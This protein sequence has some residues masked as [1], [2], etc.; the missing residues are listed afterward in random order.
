VLDLAGSFDRTRG[1]SA[2]VDLAALREYRVRVRD[3]DDDTA[4]ATGHHDLARLSTLAADR[5]ALLDEL[6]RVTRPGG[7]RAFA[8]N[9]TE[10]ARKR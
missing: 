6:G 7:R 1:S 5:Q 2:V 8:N 3:L 10:R 4:E 9:P